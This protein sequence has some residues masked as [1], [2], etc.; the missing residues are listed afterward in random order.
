MFYFITW[1]CEFDF[2]GAA[3][4]SGFWADSQLRISENAPVERWQS[5]NF[6]LLSPSLKAGKGRP[7]R[8]QEA[9]FTGKSSRAS[10]N[11]HLPLEGNAA[12]S[13]ASSSFSFLPSTFS[14]P[15]PGN[16]AFEQIHRNMLI[17]RQLRLPLPWSVHSPVGEW[18][19][20]NEHLSNSVLLL[21]LKIFKSVPSR[22]FQALRG[23]VSL[24]WNNFS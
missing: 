20:K 17:D 12:F 16:K 23:T 10:S 19:R 3:G 6:Q 21:Y 14:L 4:H 11:Q 22:S 9:S 2:L 7:S 15:L 5:P 13:P 8:A 18:K 24:S 1:C